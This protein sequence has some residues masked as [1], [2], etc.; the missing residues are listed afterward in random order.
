MAAMRTGMS[1]EAAYAATRGWLLNK[2][3]RLL[4]QLSIPKSVRREAVQT[5]A[6]L[7]ALRADRE[8]SLAKQVQGLRELLALEEEKSNELALA[9][10]N[11]AKVDRQI[12]RTYLQF[13][14]K[15]KEL[16]LPRRPHERVEE[17]GGRSEE[18]G[19]V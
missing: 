13:R 4:Q 17:S 14:A 10:A 15:S 9:G 3:P 1:E 19:K 6:S 11:E 12:P 16:V 5:P 7:G 2:G 8:L 18:S